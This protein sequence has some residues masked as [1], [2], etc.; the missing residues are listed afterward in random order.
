MRTAAIL[1]L[2]LP[3]ALMLWFHN[4]PAVP[5]SR[6]PPLPRIAPAPS[7]NL[8]S[9]DGVQVSLA[10]FRGKVVAV[11]F[12]Y[13]FCADACQVLTPMMSLVQ[14]QL[15]PDFGTNIAFVSITLDPERDTPAV[16]K[17]YAQ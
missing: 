12:I 11:T 17:E 16:L 10:D 5:P 3:A 2:A 6:E 7:F 1:A 13:T 4:D 9:Q 15:G 8:T 14:D